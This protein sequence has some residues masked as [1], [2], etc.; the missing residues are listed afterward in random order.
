MILK[1]VSK[2]TKGGWPEQSP[3]Q[4]TR[5]ELKALKSRPAPPIFLSTRCEHTKPC[6]HHQKALLG[7]PVVESLVYGHRCR[8]RQRLPWGEC[9]TLSE[10]GVE[11]PALSTKQGFSLC[12]PSQA[13]SAS[14]IVFSV[15]KLVVLWGCSVERRSRRTDSLSSS[16]TSSWRLVQS[17]F[18]PQRIYPRSPCS[19]S[20]EPS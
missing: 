18:S 4:G 14:C 2:A 12:P 6:G 5:A 17:A 10:A 11:K 19:P 16:R 13:P 7:I 20:Q 3:P 8:R 15:A 9:A 1:F